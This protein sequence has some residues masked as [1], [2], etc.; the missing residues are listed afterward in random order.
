ME[1][2]L[3]ELLPE[4]T[5]KMWY[6]LTAEMY[7]LYDVDRTWNKGFG[8]WDIEYKYR[9]GGKTLCTLYAKKDAA[10]LLILIS[11]HKVDKKSVQKLAYMGFVRIFCLYFD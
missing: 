1:E 4:D 2:K 5:L 6:A 7:K 10:I 9:R 11:Y 3:K 8:C